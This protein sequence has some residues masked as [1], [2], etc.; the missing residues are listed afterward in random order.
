MNAATITAVIAAVTTSAPGPMVGA[1]GAGA[2]RD[3]LPEDV[4]CV[5]AARGCN[6]AK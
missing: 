2:V 6:F 5:T 3:A 1:A 4:E